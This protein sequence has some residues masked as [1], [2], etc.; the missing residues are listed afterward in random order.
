[1][2][3]GWWGRWMWMEDEWMSS[4]NA[5]GGWESRIKTLISLRPRGPAEADIMSM[6]LKHN[7]ILDV[8]DFLQIHAAA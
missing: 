7:I 8:L 3:K 2:E 6:N 5:D 4:M 1:M